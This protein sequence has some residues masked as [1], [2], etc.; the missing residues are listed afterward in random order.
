[1][2]LKIPVFRASHESNNVNIEPFCRFSLQIACYQGIRA[3]DWSAT[4]CVAHHSVLRDLGNQAS[5]RLQPQRGANP[6]AL[7]IDGR[8]NRTPPWAGARPRPSDQPDT[9]LPSR[10]C[11]R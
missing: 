8:S 11:Q 2:L 9:N 3:R 5:E 7:P 1:M 4:N 10:P 6:G